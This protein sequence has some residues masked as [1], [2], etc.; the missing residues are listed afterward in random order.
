MDPVDEPGLL[1]SIAHI[2]GVRAEENQVVNSN[3]Y[4]HE[5][6]SGGRHFRE[7]LPW[8]RK[9]NWVTPMFDSVMRA[10][11]VIVVGGLTAFVTYVAVTARQHDSGA[12][13]PTTVPASVLGVS[14]ERSADHGVVLQGD[15]VSIDCAVGHPI[16]VTVSNS[17]THS[18]PIVLQEC[19]D[20]V[21]TTTSIP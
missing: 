20:P 1:G 16:A 11:G 13:T 8:W 21:G 2:K 3:P 5:R 12:S 6:H 14:V 15:G 19:A 4:H 9:P 17:R 18:A 10:L 7:D